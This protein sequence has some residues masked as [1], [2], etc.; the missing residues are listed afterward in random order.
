FGQ[1]AEGER[2][3]WGRCACG[4]VLPHSKNERVRM[5]GGRATGVLPARWAQVAERCR[6]TEV[7]DGLADAPYVGLVSGVVGG[8]LDEERAGPALG[9]SVGADRHNAGARSKQA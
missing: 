4:G 6:D 3:G 8:D 2:W 7:V 5:R 1:V 9:Q